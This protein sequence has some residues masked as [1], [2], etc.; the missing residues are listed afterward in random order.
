MPSSGFAKAVMI[1]PA[2][3]NPPDRASAGV[4]G[5]NAPNREQA[6]APESTQKRHLMCGFVWTL[7]EAS[8]VAR[9]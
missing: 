5:E 1:E 9:F 8:A 7:P 6:S 3:A 4:Q 2:I